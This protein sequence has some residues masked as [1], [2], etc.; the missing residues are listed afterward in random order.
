MK[1]TFKELST[2]RAA[3]TSAEKHSYLALFGKKN[4]ILLMQKAAH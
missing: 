1:T 2:D 3:E 4:V